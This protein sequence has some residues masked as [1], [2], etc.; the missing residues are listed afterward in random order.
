MPEPDTPVTAAEIHAY[1]ER[2]YS[3]HS[4][5]GVCAG[6]SAMVDQFLRVEALF[7]WQDQLVVAGSFRQI[8]GVYSPGVATWDG[9]AEIVH[10]HGQPPGVIEGLLLRIGIAIGNFLD[11]FLI[12]FHRQAILLDLGETLPE[13]EKRDSLAARIVARDI[14]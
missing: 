13:L 10:R 1:A 4:A 12:V 11:R 7:V 14:G 9:A 8:G 6:P 3:F 5:Q 2:N